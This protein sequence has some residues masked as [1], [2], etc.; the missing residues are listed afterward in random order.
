MR[1]ALQLPAQLLAALARL[2]LIVGSGALLHV[3]PL[4]SESALE[5]A[6]AP[7]AAALSSSR[8][9]VPSCDSTPAEIAARTNA[10]LA[11]LRA[12]GYT[13]RA[14][15]FEVLSWTGPAPGGTSI[16]IILLRHYFISTY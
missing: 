13:I 7:A 6:I 15:K 1:A 5:L 14:G 10:T 9:T 16:D 4:A 12:Q 11:A 2:Q 8:Q 3:A